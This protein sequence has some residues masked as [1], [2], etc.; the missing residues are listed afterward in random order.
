MSNT[1]DYLQWRGDLSLNSAPLCDVDLLVFSQ[2]AYIPF[3]R[4]VPPNFSDSVALSDAS[5]AV[6]DEAR[7]HKHGT[8][9][10]WRE[11]ESLITL[12]GS[13]ERFRNVRLTGFL[14]ILS[15]EQEEQ[16]AAVTAL[17]PDGS[18]VVTFRGTD[19]S[20]VGWKEDFDLAV[21]EAIPA[22]REAVKYITELSKAF[23]GK[24][25]LTGHSKG[26]NLAV[27]SYAFAPDSV[28]PQLLGA[29][30]FD[31]PG[32]N[33]KVISSEK[34]KS[35]SSEV[36]TILPNSSVIGMLLGHDEDFRIIESSNYNIF[37][38]D[39]YSWKV[40]G[41]DF[42]TAEKF[43]NSSQLIDTTL[44]SWISSMPDEMRR[45]L[46]DII[47][48]E[49]NSSQS[50]NV[51]EALL[52]TGILPRIDRLDRESAKL[53]IDATRR[54]NGAVTDTFRQFISKSNRKL[55]F[56]AKKKGD[57]PQESESQ[58]PLLK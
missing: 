37:Q 20:V 43:T 4:I 27:F 11:D 44:K 57:A 7:H 56:L 6:I 52:K 42:I 54:F 28:K 22:Q 47:F 23:D 32:F 5:A 19:I 31:G 55:F 38:H 33:E 21:S 30:N 29:R 14:N 12:L 53:V 49:L 9:F 48:T 35:I 3:D 10:F 15:T 26:G 51:I 1:I 46:I 16:F 13:C 58:T 17:L 45:K 50:S 39:P 41:P 36:K 8:F 2:M 18:A 25:M 40:S 34:L 24:V